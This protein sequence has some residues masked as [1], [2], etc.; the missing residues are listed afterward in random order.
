MP[1]TLK[2]DPVLFLATIALVCVSIVM[3]WSASAVVAME[4]YQ[5]PY[6]FLIKQLLWSIM[7]LAVLWGAMSVD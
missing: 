6:L 3:V 1:R 2:S 5:Q 7:G 4:R